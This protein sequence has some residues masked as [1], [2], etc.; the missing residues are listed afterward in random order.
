MRQPVR[1]SGS[2]TMIVVILATVITGTH[3]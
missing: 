1:R 3:A 2:M